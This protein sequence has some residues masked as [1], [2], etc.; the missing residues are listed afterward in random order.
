MRRIRDWYAPQ[1]LLCASCA[2]SDCL[3]CA[4]NYNF[5]T[6]EVDVQYDGKAELEVR[7]RSPRARVLPA[8]CCVHETDTEFFPSCCVV[9]PGEGSNPNRPP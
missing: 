9:G 1:Q 8:P 4:G 5:G 7:R 2:A 6:K 3:R